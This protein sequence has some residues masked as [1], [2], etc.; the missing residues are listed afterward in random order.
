MPKGHIISQLFK[1]DYGKPLIPTPGQI[2]IYEAIAFKENRRVNIETY[3]QYGKSLFVALGILSRAASKPEKWPI[4]APSLDKTQIIMGYVIQHLFDHPMFYSQLII[5]SS[6]EKLKHERSKTRLTFKRGGEIVCYTANAASKARVK[7]ALMGYGGQNVIIEEAGILEDDVQATALRMIMGHPKDNFIAKLGNTW[8]RNH[9]YKSHNSSKYHNIVIDYKQGL[10]E[11]RCNP[12]DIEEARELPYFDILYEV[13]FPPEDTID[14]HGY[15][16][17]LLMDEIQA[18]MSRSGK[19]NGE[20][21]L[22]VDIGGGG[23]Y[24]TYIG[25]QGG[26]AWIEDFNQSSDTMTNV[27]EIQR[28]HKDKGYK[29]DNIFVDDIGI[30]R[31][32]T[33]RLNELDCT[34]NAISVGTPAYN[35]DRFKNLK[36]ELSWRMRNWIRDPDS[37]LEKNDKFLELEVLKYKKATGTEKLM[38]EPK[39]EQRARGI[40]S[41]DFAEGLMLTF[42]DQVAQAGA[43]ST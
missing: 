2:E 29:Y 4:V 6:L 32:V 30:G 17:L 20:K 11:G 40:K 43:W 28:L 39:E 31:G 1:D 3:T 19:V 12:D 23:D 8:S 35:D 36:A 21:K 22:G 34:V 10:R 24:N 33:D 42:A 25:R 38:M 26:R 14:S 37:G 5:D 13:I 27:R 7:K 18:C 9:F 15:K 16:L 41:P